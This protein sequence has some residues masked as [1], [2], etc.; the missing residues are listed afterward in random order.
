[1][2]H[3]TVWTA[4]LLTAISLPCAAVPD[5]SGQITNTATVGGNQPDPTPGNNED[6]EP[7]TVEPEADLAVV[8]SDN[9]DPVVAGETL[10]YTLVA[11]NNGPSAATGVRVTDT[12]PAEVTLV[13]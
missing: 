9:P 3:R 4:A 12:L 13:E 8:K 1:M 2:K 10:T 5:A 6:E 7:T 11:R